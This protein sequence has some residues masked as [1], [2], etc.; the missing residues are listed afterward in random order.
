M[1]SRWMEHCC[2]WRN[3]W[4]QSANHVSNNRA[5]SVL[6]AFID[7]FGLP[8]RVRVDGGGEN[9][10]VAQYMREHPE[11]AGQDG[12]VLVGRSVHNQRI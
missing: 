11:R 8:S 4:I 5:T 7:E 1:A 12:S 3:I 6:S 9:V 2:T 10:I